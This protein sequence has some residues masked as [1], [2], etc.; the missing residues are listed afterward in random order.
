ML[1]QMIAIPPVRNLPAPPAGLLPIS[2]ANIVVAVRNSGEEQRLA[3]YLK[4]SFSALLVPSIPGIYKILAI[5]QVDAIIIDTG[6]FPGEA[7]YLCAELKTSRE[8]GHIPVILLFPTTSARLRIQCLEAGADALLEKP[9][10][11]THLLAQIRNLDRNRTRIREYFAQPHSD[12]PSPGTDTAAFAPAANP[13]FLKELNHLISNNL[14]NADLNIDLLAR[15]MHMS[16]P[17]FY[18]KLK[19]TTQYSPLELINS[20]RMKKAAELITRTDHTIAE[21][22]HMAGFRSRSNFGKA[23]Y[24]HFH[25]S[26]TDFRTKHGAS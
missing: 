13:G 14:S 21:I 24:R 26:P 1:Q 10:S 7:T 5:R 23:F 20:A 17:T 25:L 2:T 6:S 12:Q 22:M 9:Y 3:S 19:A 16:R 18:R 11:K 15:L 4:G 8:F